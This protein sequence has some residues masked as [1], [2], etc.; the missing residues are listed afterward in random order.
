MQERVRGAADDFEMLSR[1]FELAAA[2][3]EAAA[4]VAADFRASN[5]TENFPGEPSDAYLRLLEEVLE[6]YG[7]TTDGATTL[8]TLVRERLA[9]NASDGSIASARSRVA[10]R[11]RRLEA[12][13]KPLFKRLCELPVDS[14]RLR[15]E[16]RRA[17]RAWRLCAESNRSAAHRMAPPL[18]EFATSLASD[19]FEP[20]LAL[21]THLTS[22]CSIE[23]STAA[24]RLYEASPR[25]GANALKLF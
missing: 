20:L 12:C 6:I 14:S 17:L 10:K 2:A 7:K 8:M 18:E 24:G 22:T 16:D 13:A 25:D 21:H 1:A 23:V 19:V 5:G 4:G 3:F 11:V 9:L 15:G